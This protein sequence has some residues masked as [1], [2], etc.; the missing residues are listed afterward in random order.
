[1]KKCPDCAELIQDEA[2]VCRFCRKD[3]TTAPPRA[4]TPAAQGRSS[5]CLIV[6]VGL[7]VIVV[8]G[9]LVG[10]DEAHDNQ[11]ASTSQKRSAAPPDP[12]LVRV[13][14]EAQLRQALRDPESMTTRNVRVP[15]GRYYACG[16]VNSRNAF[17]GMTGF[18][19]FIAGPL[20]STPTAVEGENI[21]DREFQVAW[22]EL[23]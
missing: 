15:A 11:T 17:G 22:R 20:A 6:V 14:A 4:A 10:R 19:R 13:R 16:E 8:I 7:I 3:L 9:N 18:K 21:T 1:M 23:C 12:A 5:G 2:R